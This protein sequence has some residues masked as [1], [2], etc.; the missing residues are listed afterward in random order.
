MAHAYVTERV[1]HALMGED[2]IGQRQ[3]C[4][5]VGRFVRHGQVL[6][7]AAA[8]TRL[9][10]E[11]IMSRHAAWICRPWPRRSTIKRAYGG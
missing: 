7:M 4:D 8:P 10:A 3:L 5:E 11:L 6:E 9:L 1:E 2:A